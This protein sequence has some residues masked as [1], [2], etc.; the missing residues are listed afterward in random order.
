[1]RVTLDTDVLVYAVDVSAGPRH[2]FASDLVERATE[3]DCVLAL[4]A[5]VEFFDVATRRR[6]LTPTAAQAYLSDWRRVFAVVA[7]T[8]SEFEAAIGAHVD[9]GLSIWDAMIWAVA[10]ASECDVLLTEDLQDGRRLGR[11]QF[12]NPFDPANRRLVD[13][14]LPPL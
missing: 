6:R 10:Q 13:T 14:I 8:L 12:V 7:A 2:E 4:Q 5:L 3:V 1:V 11:V 9:H